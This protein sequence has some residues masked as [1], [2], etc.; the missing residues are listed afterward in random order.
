MELKGLG[1][2]SAMSQAQTY[3]T[4]LRIH[5]IGKAI[6]EFLFS[7]FK[8]PLAKLRGLRVVEL[9]SISS[10]ADVFLCG[11]LVPYLLSLEELG[12]VSVISVTWGERRIGEDARVEF[13]KVEGLLEERNRK[14]LAERP[15]Q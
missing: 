2:L 5:V 13:T 15:A 14:F 4:H 12:H 1:P 8:V 3:L 9:M 10:R 11:E 6:D 7:D